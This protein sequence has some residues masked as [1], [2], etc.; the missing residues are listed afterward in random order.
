MPFSMSA[1]RF[2]R[3]YGD[4][5]ALIR[6]SIVFGRLGNLHVALASQNSTDS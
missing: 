2:L 1:I 5:V 3:A 4:G 6:V